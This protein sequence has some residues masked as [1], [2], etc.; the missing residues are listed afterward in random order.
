MA[1]CGGV[2][3]APAGS[4]GDWQSM[5]RHYMVE[6]G[7]LLLGQVRFGSPKCSGL[8][9]YLVES[10]LDWYCPVGRGVLMQGIM[11]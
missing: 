5:V 2:G 8:R 6:R 3:S 10:S 1:L 7:P 9:N 11:S 4:S